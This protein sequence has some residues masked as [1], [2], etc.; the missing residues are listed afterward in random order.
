[1]EQHTLR[2]NSKLL[3]RSMAKTNSSNFKVPDLRGEFVRGFDN[4]R[5]VDSGRGDA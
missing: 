3:E 4:G 5:G 2:C 1:M